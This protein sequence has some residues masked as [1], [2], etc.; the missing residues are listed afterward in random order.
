MLGNFLEMDRAI[1]KSKWEKYR[2]FI[3]SGI[4]IAIMTLLY[5][6]FFSFKTRSLNVAKEKLS[7]E[8]IQKSFFQEFIAINGNVRPMR[9]IALV[10]IVGGIVQEKYLEDGAF[11]KQGD[12]LLKLS[13]QDLQLDFMNRE[14]ALLDQLNNLRNTRISMEQNHLKLMQQLL[15]MENDYTLKKRTYEINKQLIKDKIIATNEYQQ[16]E[17]GYKSASNKYELL[18]QSVYKDS[19]NNN[20]QIQQLNFSSDLI[21]KNLELVKQNMDN[22]VIKAPVSGQLTTLNAEIGE[23]KTKGESLGQVDVME[24]FKVNAKIDEHYISRIS[25]GLKG[26][27]DLNGSSYS[28]TVKKV[29]PQVKD[30]QFQ[31]DLE[32]EKNVPKDIKQGQSLQVRLTLGE[33]TQ[34]VLVNKGGFFQKTGGNWIFVIINNKAVKRNIKLGRQNPDYYEVI[35]GLTPGEKVITSNYEVFGDAE[36]LNFE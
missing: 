23:N 3:L 13:N 29:Y 24:G 18:K 17:D 1:Q 6:S 5:S 2:K 10:A 32:F 20:Y 19:V 28:L 34:A 16:S 11:V 12:P 9:T 35:E 30:G 7:V 33:A 8:T 31:V 15:D 25:P 14:T 27:F 36:E 22:L 26:E 4:A 21:Q